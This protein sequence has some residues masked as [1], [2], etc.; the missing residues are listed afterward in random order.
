MIQVIAVVVGSSSKSGFV[1]GGTA[2]VIL[3]R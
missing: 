1:A 3:Q 2:M